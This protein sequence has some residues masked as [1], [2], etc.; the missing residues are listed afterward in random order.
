M[1]LLYRINVSIENPYVLGIL[2]VEESNFV[3]V[4]A[5][6]TIQNSSCCSLERPSFYEIY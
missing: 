2:F 5:Q 1:K 6:V 4:Q 3:R